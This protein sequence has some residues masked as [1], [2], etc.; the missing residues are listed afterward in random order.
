MQVLILCGGMGTRAYPF[1]EYLPKPMLPINGTPILVHVMRIFADQGHR[2]FVL[3]VGYR[4][5]AIQDYFEGKRE[6]NVE[7]VDTGL[8]SDTG[9]RI[10]GC[11]HLLGPTFFATYADGLS[12]VPLD[13][14]LAFHR[15]HKGLA[16][17]TCVPMRS[18]YGTLETRE[19]GEVIRFREKP[20]LREHWINAG[21]F[22]FDREVFDHWAGTNLEREVFPAL[23][24]RG[25]V[26][27]YRHDGF[28][29]SVDSYKDHHEL[30]QMLAEDA[31]PWRARAA[32][33]RT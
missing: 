9:E 32:S 19:S 29:K 17:V 15:S 23:A 26:Y 8:H 25:L 30:E 21:F 3:S 22:V 5:E 7:L 28:F 11:R 6:W 27:G 31:S 33:K 16:T 20:V 18:Q 2:D 10:A 13:A 12:D 1:T 24:A 14:L 4:K